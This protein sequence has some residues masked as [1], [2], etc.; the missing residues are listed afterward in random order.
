MEKE[1]KTIGEE[2]T[3]A[4]ETMKEAGKAGKEISK[5]PVK[6]K[7]QTDTP[8]KGKGKSAKKDEAAKLQE[9]IDRKTKE[10]ER[11]LA[12]L[13]RKKEI[14]RNRTAFINAMDKLEEAADKLKEENTFET[15]FYK[16]R[17]TEA[18]YSGN[19]IFTISNRFLLEE[20]TGFM[21]KKIQSKI[22]ELEQLLINE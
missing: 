9:E 8:A 15:A 10:L 4:V 6:E 7:K 22:E 1:V 14:S 5:Q 2:L 20:F 12:E 21:K 11:C 3:K 13:E 19:D 18:G 17:F 16:L